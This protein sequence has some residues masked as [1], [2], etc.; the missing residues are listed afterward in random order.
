[1]QEVRE[2]LG[3]AETS[4]EASTEGPTQPED[5]APSDEPAP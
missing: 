5:G 1:M 3:G 2:M 4:T